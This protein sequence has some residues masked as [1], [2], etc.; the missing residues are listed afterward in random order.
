MEHST[1]LNA[2]SVA[3]AYEQ[4]DFECV[5][6]EE[7]VRLSREHPNTASKGRYRRMVTE[8]NT[9]RAC[10]SSRT[11][12][13]A[14]SRS[15]P[16]A[17]SAPGPADR[18]NRSVGSGLEIILRAPP[19][20]S[21]VMTKS[22]AVPLPFDG[23]RADVSAIRNAPANYSASLRLPHQRNK[24]NTSAY[25][26]MSNANNKESRGET[27]S[28]SP[29]SKP[30]NLEVQV[31][32]DSM[33]AGFGPDSSN[34]EI[35]NRFPTAGVTRPETQWARGCQHAEARDLLFVRIH[36]SVTPRATPCRRLE[37]R[38]RKRHPQECTD[39]RG[40]QVFHEKLFIKDI[41][42]CASIELPESRLAG[43]PL[44]SRNKSLRGYHIA[45]RL[46]KHKFLVERNGY[47]PSL[48]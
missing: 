41:N 35:L 47:T 45:T 15:L 8:K 34:S 28:L 22:H 13:P 30:H 43:I 20:T 24:A 3:T 21:S 10:A 17:R 31:P 12:R 39:F 38:D 25:V 36:G 6:I 7:F 9:S 19:R 4:A 42:C 14:I 40:I 5:T 46:H 1:G 16:S 23:R 48:P 37:N 32:R 33:L 44:Q 29:N 26:S 11:T 2:Y 18:K 27:L